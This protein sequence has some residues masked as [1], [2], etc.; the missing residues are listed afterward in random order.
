MCTTTSAR[1]ASGSKATPPSMMNARL[2]ASTMPTVATHLGGGGYGRGRGGAGREVGGRMPASP[3]G[4]AH[5]CSPGSKASGGAGHPGL[6]ALPA[7]SRPSPAHHTIWRP[8]RSRSSRRSST[9]A[10]ASSSAAKE[11]L[12]KATSRATW[13][14]YRSGGRSGCRRCCAGVS[15]AAGQGSGRAHTL[16]PVRAAILHS[17][18]SSQRAGPATHLSAWL[19]NCWM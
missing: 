10:S 3:A 5:S 4:E 11:P 13:L 14:H 7:G 9:S 2:S 18:P 19:G 8:H 16:S 15:R 12:T 1:A 6:A 17:M